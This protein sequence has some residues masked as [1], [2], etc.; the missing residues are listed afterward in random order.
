MDLCTFAFRKI[1]F[2]DD[3]ARG[4]IVDSL[5]ECVSTTTNFSRL[6]QSD[7]F[8]DTINDRKTKQFD[9][10]GNWVTRRRGFSLFCSEIVDYLLLKFNPRRARCA[11]KATGYCFFIF[12]RGR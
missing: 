5:V 10:R 6:S 2:L 3:R 8:C 11:D 4:T 1:R 9:F 12:L 7:A